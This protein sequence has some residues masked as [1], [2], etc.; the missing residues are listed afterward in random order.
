[1]PSL[2]DIG[3]SG[4]QAYR[5]SLAVT[6]QNIANINTEGYKKR[7][8]ALAEVS[9]AGGG[10]TEISDQTGLGV[11][12]DEIRRAFDEFLIDK[13]RQ[14][15]S[16]YQKT[17]A[18]VNEVKDLENLLLPGDYNLSSS[19]GD[20]FNS[21]QEIAAAPDDQAP[22][23]VSIEKGKDLAS[24]FNLY[25]DRINN[26]KERLSNQAQNGVTSVNII[27]KQLAD[28]NEDLLNSGL[29][30][31]ASNAKL[32]Q[33]DNLLDKI[34]KIAQITVAY[35][36]RGEALVR[37]G[38]TGSGPVLVQNNSFS[39]L[40]IVEKDGRLQA[41]IGLNNTATNQIQ[42]GLISGYTDAYS[43]ATD[44]HNEIDNLAILISNN[45]NLIN[46]SGL[47]L[48]GEVGKSMFAVNNL[49]ATAGPTNRSTVGVE[50][51]STDPSLVVKANYTVSYSQA[52][53]QWSLTAPHL[54]NSI[55]GKNEINAEGFKLNFFGNPL[56]ADEFIL[57]PSNE[58]KAIQFLLTRPQDIAAAA[59]SLISSSSSNLGTATLTEK[60][61]IPETDYTT[62]NEIKNVFANGLNP[63]TSTEFST[64]GGAAIIPIGTSSLD[65]S[66]YIAQ[67]K[68]QFGVSS[69]D[70]TSLT[71]T[72]ITLA[73]TSS[74][75]VDLT[76][77]ATIQ[78]VAD[79]LNNGIDVNGSAHTFR[80][81]GLFAAAG[82]STLSIVSNDQN[83][84]SATLSAG[85]TLNGVITNPS[86]SNA[87]NLQIFTKEGRHLAGTV[88]SSSEIATFLTKE[89]GF[90]SSYEYRAD[91][92]NGT[93]TNKYRGIEIDRTTVGGNFTI[94]YGS[95]G[96]SVSAQRAASTIP[97]SHVTSAYTLT[98][99]PS[100][101]SAVDISVPIESSSGFV[102]NLINTNA[103]NT[104]I[105]ASAI[106]R[107]KIP[108]PTTDGTISFIL[109]SKSGTNSTASI[110]ASVTTSD[111]T[112]LATSV[113]NFTGLTGVSAHLATDKKSLIIENIDG[114]DIELTS[115][116]QPGTKT[117][118]TSS[119]SSGTTLTSASHGFSTGDKIIYT[120]GGTA[121]T[122][123]TSG[124]TYYAIKVS[125]NTFK[126]ASSS[127][128]ASSGTA[129][130]IGGANGSSTDIFSNPL[131]LEI[132]KD[133]YTSTSSSVDIDGTSYS[134]ARFSGQL[135][136]ES[137]LSFTTT[138]DSGSTTVSSSQNSFKDGYLEVTSSSTGEIKTIKPKVFSGDISASHPNG[139][140]ASSS[141]A[142]YGLTLPQ[143]G[144]G[145]SF[146]TT[147][148][149]SKLNNLNSAKVS[150]LIAE[151]LRTN[152]PSIE[153]SGNSISTLPAD[154]SAFKINHDGLTYTL[155]M[156]NGEVIVSGGETKL[157]NAYFEDKDAL[158]VDTS[159]FSNTSSI[160]YTEHGLR[161]G[162]A[163]TYNAA[164]KITVDTT[165]FNS[166]SSITSNSH[167]FSTGDP[168][169]YTAK[170]SQA[171][172][173][174]VSGTTYYA[175]VSDSNTFGL[176][177]TSNNASNG[178]TFSITGGTGGSLVDTFASPITGLTDG[179][180]YFVV[181]TN[182][183]SFQIA[184]TYSLATSSSPT[185]LTITGGSGG[186][187]SDTFDPGQNLYLSARSCI[188]A[189]Q[190][191]FATDSINDTNAALFG[192]S[193]TNITTSITGKSVTNPSVSST[194]M[195]ISLDRSTPYDLGFDNNSKTVNTTSI[196][197]SSTTITSS[198]HGFKT[199][200][201]I[202]YT[203][204]G[205]AMTGLTNGTSYYAKV[206]D[207]NTF[208]LA[209]SFANAT[210]DSPT[211]LSFGGGNGNASDTFSTVIG[212]IFD[213]DYGYSGGNVSGT[214][215]TNIGVTVEITQVSD[216]N[217]QISIIKEADKN[218]ITIDTITHADG[219]N[220]ETFG[221]KTNLS[222]VNVINDDIKISNIATDFV[223][224]TSVNIEVPSNGIASLSGSNLSI[225][226][227]P[228]EDL[229]ILLTGSGAR[230]VAA[231]Y[232]EV[233]PTIEDTEYKLV[234]DSGNNKKVE[235]LEAS[236]LHSIGTRLI[237][238]SGI[239]T[240]S[241][242][243]LEFNGSANVNDTFTITNNK[244]GIGDNR[245]ILEMLALQEADITGINSGSFQDIFNATVAE[246][247]ST[248]RSGELSLETAQASKDEA[249]ALENEMAGVS[250]DEEASSLMQ[251]QQAYQA[252]ARII[253]TAR[254]LF[255]SLLSVIRS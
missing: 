62:L 230:K 22:R 43:L 133:D 237:P 205:T 214:E 12:V 162:D 44:T 208:S 144:S 6:G 53:N 13:A 31:Q 34:S 216:T 253:Q 111:L 160:S 26:L 40:G 23:I 199:G 71:S 164:E 170:G 56:D 158:T 32:D 152:S 130:T 247:G 140:D 102:A 57:T 184:D 72:T 246:I 165:N 87:S 202:L 51:T 195:H 148:D 7:D 241:G 9:A 235:I 200:D 231:T 137:S 215:V 46:S 225:S 115:F 167:G 204:A 232:G 131:T 228:P 242:K 103:N 73:D 254:E 132:L 153:I 89:N 188:S 234:I 83:F 68:V 141:V 117:I 99:T 142:K 155:T 69:S 159:S 50:V 65:L 96:T 70:I 77:V 196:S 223:S 201:K 248:V 174:L 127:S 151:G 249:E 95:N 64:D 143:T 4:L 166:T 100:N 93:G 38:N 182:E 67:P 135:N 121:M 146:T 3:K 113:N 108:A 139:T 126:L 149:V 20:F 82:G 129:L 168:I 251:F 97:A 41:T 147:V 197:G 169:V 187:A 134:A 8:A 192:M 229:I 61:L 177:T 179:E 49:T 178:T 35:G 189:S 250:M 112:N 88:L 244:D 75:T 203:A 172:N 207:A 101:S 156:Q 59:A 175:V 18:Y 94:S 91:Y 154:G 206:V 125:D 193:D 252:N 29:T 55:T 19:I 186:N 124:N 222:Q 190:F 63:V 74:V 17:D 105:R 219:S 30:S 85:S 36:S 181:K 58:S 209:S 81:L 138:N 15:S 116:T 25:S 1:M 66:S 191:S 37:L 5:N 236:T 180:T 136:L 106:T 107:L 224:G 218:S 27:A 176:A 52:S 183:H 157:I 21:L 226:N 24:Q 213:N 211:L 98:L 227:M 114:D 2:F 33:R 239:I 39:N 120:A 221:F 161:T 104:G 54:S 11:R 92:I 28:I 220:A 45:F 128:N 243:T 245:N 42:G 10:V 255:E 233:S 16:I 78:E 217:C 123:L 14:T 118:D 210:A 90:N 47:N 48:D 150:K 173:G 79:I 119:F 198:S 84:S 80:T 238:E 240:V 194:H 185:V 163:V 86:V 145:T 171:I 122:N 110:N 109:K 76:G 60:T 212:K